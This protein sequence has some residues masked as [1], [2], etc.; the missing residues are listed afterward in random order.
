MYVRLCTRLDIAHSVGAM[1]QFM[2]NLGREHWEGVKWLLHYLK[3]TFWGLFIL[4]KK[5]VILE[6][7]AEANLCVEL[8]VGVALI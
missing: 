2:S 5:M 4:Q 7:F 8:I 6:G 3:G 1:S